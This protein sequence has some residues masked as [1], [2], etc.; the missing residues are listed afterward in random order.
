MNLK[1]QSAILHTH[2]EKVL[3]LFSGDSALILVFLL[4]LLLHF[5]VVVAVLIVQYTFKGLDQNTSFFTV[6]YLST[7]LKGVS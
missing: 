4:L 3:E 1:K 6:L 2:A 5:V 7:L